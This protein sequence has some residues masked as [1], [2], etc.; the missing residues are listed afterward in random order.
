MSEESIKI[1]FYIGK[2]Y[3]YDKETLAN[4]TKSYYLKEVENIEPHDNWND[5]IQ[6]IVIN[7]SNDLMKETK[8]IFTKELDEIKDYI[9]EILSNSWRFYNIDFKFQT[10]NIALLQN[11]SIIQ[12]FVEGYFF[13]QDRIIY[14][15]YP[16]LT[17]PP[18]N[19]QFESQFA[20]TKEEEFYYDSVTH[21]VK[22]KFIPYFNNMGN[23]I[24]HNFDIK[25]IRSYLDCKTRNS[26]FL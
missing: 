11:R 7:F 22:E 20:V 2:T 5:I 16:I 1:H 14:D 8:P 21:L 13:N 23:I 18:I 6:N 26:K 4:L 25:D 15:S 10:K 3:D 24:S 9:I 19:M 12:D 17:T